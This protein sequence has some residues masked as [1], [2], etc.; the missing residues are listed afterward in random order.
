MK[1]NHTFT[2][3]NEEQIEHFLDWREMYDPP[4]VFKLFACKTEVY[5]DPDDGKSYYRTIIDVFIRDNNDPPVETLPDVP[6]GKG[7]Q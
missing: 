4:G 5:H 1:K 2:L 7:T 6:D 3:E